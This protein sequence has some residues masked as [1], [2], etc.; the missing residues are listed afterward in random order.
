MKIGSKELIVFHS[1]TERLKLVSENNLREFCVMVK[2]TYPVLIS[3][4]GIQY[5]SPKGFVTTILMELGK[6]LF[7]TSLTVGACK[8]SA[9]LQDK[10]IRDSPRHNILDLRVVMA[11]HP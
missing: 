6:S 3:S 5:G 2:F 10:S 11:C 1:F 8:V 7:W 9:R 4:A